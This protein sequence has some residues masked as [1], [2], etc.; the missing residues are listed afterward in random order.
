MSPAIQQ[1]EKDSL[2][3]LVKM[4]HALL[5]IRVFQ[6]G[7]ILLAVGKVKQLRRNLSTIIAGRAITEQY[8]FEKKSGIK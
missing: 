5:I 7:E 6:Q 4:I 1:M 8:A 2:L 3:L